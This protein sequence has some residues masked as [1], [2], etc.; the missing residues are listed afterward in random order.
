MEQ[1][2]YHKVKKMD[3]EMKD[4]VGYRKARTAPAV[5]MLPV[6]ANTVERGVLFLN[7]FIVLLGVL[8]SF[9]IADVS[10]P[11]ADGSLILSFFG[12]RC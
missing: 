11:D 5:P 8:I 6:W 12:K 9:T 10:S 3:E 1:G 7:I 4:F 2:V